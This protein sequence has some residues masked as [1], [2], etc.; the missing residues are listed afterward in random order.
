MTAE[1]ALEAI[2]AR[3]TKPLDFPGLLQSVSI[4]C[5]A[6]DQPDH[7]AEMLGSLIPYDPGEIVVLL[8]V[9][10]DPSMYESCVANRCKIAEISD[11]WYYTHGSAGANVLSVALCSKPHVI[12]LDTDERFFMPQDGPIFQGD[13]DVWP[14]QRLEHNCGIENKTHFSACAFRALRRESFS[15]VQL[16]GAVHPSPGGSYAIAPDPAPFTI[17]HERDKY[18]D[19]QAN[20]NLRKK[21]LFASLT[22]KS[23]LPLTPWG[24]ANARQFH[25]VYEAWLTEGE[26]ALGPLERTNAPYRLIGEWSEEKRNI[27]IEK[28]GN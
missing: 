19:R 22:L 12:I 27:N 14:V 11:Q 23:G 17:L 4:A 3:L 28:I 1:Q 9:P 16:Y 24:E 13:Y 18:L 15:K 21:R 8:N 7:F 20:F 10:A 26:A 2:N 25:A 6:G 5:I